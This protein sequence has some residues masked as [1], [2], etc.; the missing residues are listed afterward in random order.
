[1]EDLKLLADGATWKEETSIDCLVSRLLFAEWT[2]LCEHPL[3]SESHYLRLLQKIRAL[4]KDDDGICFMLRMYAEICVSQYRTRSLRN[5]NIGMMRQ[6]DALAKLISYLIMT[7]KTAKVKLTNRA[8]SVIV[9]VL[10][11]D[12]ETS[13]ENFNQ[14]PFLALLSSVL[15]ELSR[16]H[17]CKAV[18]LGILI[19]FR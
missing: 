19:A 11:R 18:D 2:R 8:L 15:V 6:V 10:A 3:T 4:T 17:V 5:S 7:E 14:K 16:A 13:S 12:H 1:M 9:L